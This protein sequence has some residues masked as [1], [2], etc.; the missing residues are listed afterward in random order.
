MFDL[1]SP[2][3]P[4]PIRARATFI[5]AGGTVC[6]ERFPGRFAQ[7]ERLESVSCSYACVLRV[8]WAAICSRLADAV[9]RRGQRIFGTAECDQRKDEFT[10]DVETCIR[11]CRLVEL[12]RQDWRRVESCH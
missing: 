6:V 9:E 1:N 10:E 2:F 4:A 8:R 12:L 3:V 7:P 5:M 11:V